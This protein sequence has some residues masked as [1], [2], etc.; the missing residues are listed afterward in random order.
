MMNIEHGFLLFPAILVLYQDVYL[1]PVLG[2]RLS[3]LFCLH[4]S[5]PSYQASSASGIRSVEDL[6]LRV[7]ATRVVFFD[8]TVMKINARVKARRRWRRRSRE[9]Q[10]DDDLGRLQLCMRAEEGVLGMQRRRMHQQKIGGDGHEQTGDDGFHRRCCDS[11]SDF[12]QAR[13]QR[14]HDGQPMLTR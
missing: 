11:A 2:R 12:D 13:P 3:S 10:V 8:V 5:L 7:V 6:I 14:I 4:H 9:R 1:M